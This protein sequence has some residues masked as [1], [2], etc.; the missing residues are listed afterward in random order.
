MTARLF[1][2]H[3]IKTH[4]PSQIV[5]VKVLTYCGCCTYVDVDRYGLSTSN[6]YRN[7]ASSQRTLQVLLHLGVVLFSTESYAPSMS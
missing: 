7:Y 4:H 5:C 2:P 6:L 1:T 3:D